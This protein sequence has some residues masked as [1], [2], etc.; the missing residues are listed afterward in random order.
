MRAC[1]CVCACVCV[2]T[3]ARASVMWCVRACVPECVLRIKNK[4]NKKR[5]KH[6]VV[7][8]IYYKNLSAL[9]KYTH[10]YDDTQG[11]IKHF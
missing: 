2:P 7:K 11:T 3:C 4:T 1:V 10:L 8:K 6:I 9:E 5:S